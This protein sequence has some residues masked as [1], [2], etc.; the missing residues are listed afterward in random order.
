MSAVGSV[1]LGYRFFND[2]AL[3][4]GLGRDFAGKR[5]DVGKLDMYYWFGEASPDSTAWRP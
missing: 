4:A 5:L 3:E 2:W 1:N